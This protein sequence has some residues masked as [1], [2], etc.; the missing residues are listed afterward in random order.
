M[1][2]LEIE[3]KWQEF[4]ENS[5]I[6]KS[7]NNSDLPKYYVLEMFPYPSGKCHIGHLRN[8]SIG[9]VICR[10]MKGKGYNVLHPMGFDAFG[11]PAE[12]AAIANNTDPSSWTY[13]NIEV[14]RD[15]LK[16]VGLAYD[17]SREIVS[18]DP[19]YYK[20]EQ[21]FFLQLFERGIAYQKESIVN[22]DPVDNTV[23]ANEQV[24]DGRGWRSGAL[25]EKK[26]LKQWFLK[27]TDYA[28]ELLQDIDSLDAWPDSVKSMQRNWIGRSEG[29][30]FE[31]KIQKT[32]QA[33]EVFSTRPDTIFGA[34][35]IGLAYNHPLIDQFSIN[36]TNITEFVKKVAKQA[37]ASQSEGELEKEAIATGFYVD[38][39]FDRQVKLPILVT[40]F[41]LMDYGTGAVFGCPAHDARDH[42]IALKLALP[43]KQ[44]VLPDNNE[45]VNV[46]VAPYIGS[47]TIINSDFLNGL[48]VKDAKDAA[49]SEFK[50]RNIGR[51]QVNY[52]LRDWGVSR[53]RYWG[54]PIP[55]I[56]CKDC[57]IVPVRDKD[58]P[59]LLPQDVTLDGRGNPLDKH[60][61]WKYVPC[62]KC[63]SNAERETDT[64]D[65]FFESSWYFARFSNVDAKDMVSANDANYWMPVDQYIG[66]I[67][68]AILHLLYA[69]FFT[70]LMSDFGYLTSREPFKKLITQGMVLHE[71]FKDEHGK[72]VY[73]SDVYLENGEYI[74]KITKQ[75][76]F[77]GSVEKMSKSK[78]NVVDLGSVLE[79]YGADVARMFCLSDSPVEK[80]LE[81]SSAGIEGCKRFVNKLILA[82]DKLA[83]HQ[84][85]GDAEHELISLTHSTIKNVSDDIESH[86]LNKA[87]ARIRE[88]FN[89]ISDELANQV[90]NFAIAKFALHNVLRLL[91]P[92]VPHITEE[93]WF[94]LGNSKALCLMPWPKWDENKIVANSYTIAVQINGKLRA[95]VECNSNDSEDEI[96]ALVMSN[97]QVQKY[98]QNL[99]IK[100][101]II[102]PQKVI[103]I[104]V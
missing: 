19:G 29:A 104:V 28:E 59:V 54:C 5:Y 20:H 91:N 46:A 83:Q 2:I 42:E 24:E 1:N 40:N 88:L 62:P 51:S 11:L 69:R 68:H 4:W 8:Y 36:D 103:N 16:S 77:K 81:W 79:S 48:T 22:W 64:F 44:V 87:I 39:P 7:S 90:P 35:F 76:I 32:D 85:S 102:V 67:E 50:K 55:V 95:T 94:K 66:G 21:K 17:W 43:I 27:I 13:S 63:G 74:H 71:T 47:G 86:R 18:C 78:L 72:W 56:H 53:Q 49:I 3:K 38:H 45:L 30:I 99:A 60:P 80:D 101:F 98:T 34:S 33:I 23:L 96:R 57:G 41:V 15:Q 70:K 89:S 97:L 100:K 58:L 9:D 25:V 31:F 6:F 10:Y 52:K 82:S 84:E 93:L 75:K 26:Y 12:N 73:P 37:V 92:F 65:T 14:M 61:S